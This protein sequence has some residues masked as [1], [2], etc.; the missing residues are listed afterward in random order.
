MYQQYYAEQLYKK[1]YVR[2]N[3]KKNKTK[4]ASLIQLANQYRK[5]H[6]LPYDL[7]EE[8]VGL[9]PVHRMSVKDL[10]E[11]VNKCILQKHVVDDC[12]L[13]ESVHPSDQKWIKQNVA[14]K[15]YTKKSLIRAYKNVVKEHKRIKQ[16]TR[17]TRPRSSSIKI[18]PSTITDSPE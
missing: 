16:Q 10:I 3:E 5:G 15:L 12:E 18:K 8:N 2:L 9:R 11:S 14:K 17:R 7:S 4:L 6:E 13:D 1:G